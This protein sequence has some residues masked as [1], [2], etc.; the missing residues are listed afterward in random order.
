LIPGSG[1][2]PGEGNGNPY[3]YSCLGNHMDREAWWATTHGVSEES[4]MTSKINN[5]NSL[6]LTT[7]HEV[8]PVTLPI[9]QMK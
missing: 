1:R 8:D 2:P 6:I 4:D 7:I 5:N 3:Q 9:L